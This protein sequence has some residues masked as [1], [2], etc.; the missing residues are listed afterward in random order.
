MNAALEAS[1]D[2]SFT[3]SLP[4]ENGSATHTVEGLLS[5]E[6][7]HLVL[8]L[9]DPTALAS[10]QGLGLAR[11]AATSLAD[12]GVTVTVV[13]PD[14]PVVVMGV[15]HSSWL[16]RRLTGSPHMRVGRIRAALPVLRMRRG[17][18]ARAVL[19]QPPL[20]P[21]TLI[22]LAPTF[23]R[24]H[25]G[26]VTTTHDPEGGGRPCLVFAPGP[27]PWP[28]DEQRI[29]ELLPDVTTIGSAAGADLR[30]EGLSGEHAEVR[31]NSGDEFVFVQLSQ[32]SHSL[33]NGERA[34]EHVLRTGTRIE[35]GGW[36]M[37]YH[38][39]EFAD[40][41]RPYGG[42]V[43]GEIGHQRPQPPR[44]T[45]PDQQGEPDRERGH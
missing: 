37:S 23:R 41:G 7:S 38:R 26:P 21:S 29:V 32:S 2:L 17:G 28:G 40:H 45:K 9:N 22:P 16:Q 34:R 1:A 5:G 10:G 20:P 27:A 24:A 13:G 36:T 14:G 8:E 25:R 39:E 12:R 19:T 42:R 31:R 35:L 33:V 44:T 15:R 18:A 4:E 11:R 43:G 30:L 3:V 6:D